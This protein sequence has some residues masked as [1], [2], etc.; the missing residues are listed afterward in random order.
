[1]LKVW[2]YEST[3]KAVNVKNAVPTYSMLFPLTWDMDVLSGEGQQR[4]ELCCLDR[5]AVGSVVAKEC[6]MALGVV[7][8][9]TSQPCL[10]SG[11][12]INSEVERG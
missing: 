12:S 4:V 7:S 11:D 6:S 1:M 2:N 9:S 5:S 3:L 10:C 8:F